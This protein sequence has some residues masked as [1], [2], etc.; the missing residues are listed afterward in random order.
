[1]CL[2]PQAAVI[3]YQAMGLY[4]KAVQAC[5]NNNFALRRM[6]EESLP[7]PGLRQPSSAQRYVCT[8]PVPVDDMAHEFS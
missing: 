8:L 5:V 1:M 7:K 4:E 2:E 3:P 6:I